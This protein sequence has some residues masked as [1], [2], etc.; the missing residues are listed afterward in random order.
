MVLSL[1]ALCTVKQ[2]IRSELANSA[3]NLLQRFPSF[4]FMLLS[5]PASSFY[6]SI[7]MELSNH[8]VWRIRFIRI[9]H[10]F[11]GQRQGKTNS[12]MKLYA[13]HACSFAL[14]ISS[15]LI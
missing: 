15:S 6:L 12:G 14:M 4:R 13:F 5:V 3:V 9:P 2:M 7:T 11:P 10:V 1:F 8:A